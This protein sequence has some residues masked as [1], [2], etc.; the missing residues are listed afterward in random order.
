MATLA[1]RMKF[2][3]LKIRLKEEHEKKLHN[4]ELSYA[5]IIVQ[6]MREKERVHK[7]MQ[8]TFYN[9]IEQINQM[10][11]N[12]N[13]SNHNHQA[14]PDIKT[15][16][17]ETLIAAVNH[18]EANNDDIEKENQSGDCIEVENGFACRICHKVLARAYDIKR[19]IKC[20]HGDE[21]PYKCD[22][23]GSS[24]KLQ[25][26]LK[27]HKVIHLSV[28]PFKCHFCDRRFSRKRDIAKHCKRRHKEGYEQFQKAKKI[29]NR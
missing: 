12:N 5:N 2:H 22:E 19:H 21:R 28:R 27:E 23:C 29:E 1:D 16:P 17:L 26:H 7:E 15:N 13:D 10:M 18:V 4:L 11:F 9:Q 8:N 3:K 24:F 14:T 25:F 20:V 6:L